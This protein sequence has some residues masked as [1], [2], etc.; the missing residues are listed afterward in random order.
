MRIQ[1]TP[2]CPQA[3]TARQANPNFKALKIYEMVNA[4]DIRKVRHECTRKGCQL[5]KGALP[6]EFFARTKAGSAEE[7]DAIKTIEN[8]KKIGTLNKDVLV[9]SIPDDEVTKNLP[10]NY[11]VEY[12]QPEKK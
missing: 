11:R 6:T 4:S 12:V 7:Q 1:Q 10:V 9:K 5:L 8:M 2:C 3:R